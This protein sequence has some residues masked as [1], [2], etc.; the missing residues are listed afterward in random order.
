MRA[1]AEDSD[2]AVANHPTKP[3]TDKLPGDVRSKTIVQTEY[4]SDDRNLFS[5]RRTCQSVI[6][7]IDLLMTVHLSNIKVYIPPSSLTMLEIDRILQ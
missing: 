4:F 2:A 7:K 6:T 5:S 1:Q 3:M